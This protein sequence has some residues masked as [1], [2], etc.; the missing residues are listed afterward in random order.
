[1]VTAG[2]QMSQHSVVPTVSTRSAAMGKGSHADTMKLWPE[3][4]THHLPAPVC[5][6][7]QV[8]R[9]AMMNL[10]YGT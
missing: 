8:C 7:L 3:R 10:A 2:T 5:A 4:V 6:I 1:M 9:K